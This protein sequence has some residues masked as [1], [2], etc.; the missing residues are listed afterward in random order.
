MVHCDKNMSFRDGRRL[1]LSGQ[2][3]DY[4]LW[5]RPLASLVLTQGLRNRRFDV[6]DFDTSAVIRKHLDPLLPC[7]AQQVCGAE[8]E[9]LPRPEQ[10]PASFLR[11]LNDYSL[12][13]G[14]LDMKFRPNVVQRH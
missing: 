12:I 11:V 5:D 1:A 14:G 3:T 6:N 8:G 9:R 10:L 13:V 7:L 4:I 2:F